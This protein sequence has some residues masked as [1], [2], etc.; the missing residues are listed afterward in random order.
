MSARELRG[1]AS[2]GKARGKAAR[3]EAPRGSHAVLELRPD[4]D[5]IAL[6]ELQAASRLS[7]LV[8]IRYG[9]MLV[10]P[11]SFFRGAAIVMAHDLAANPAAGLRAQLCGDAHLLNFGGFA[12]PERQLVFD[13]TDFDETLPGPFEWDVKRLA[14]SFEIAA[15]ECNFSDS[16][17]RRSVLS[18]VRSYRLAMHQFAAISHLDV[19]YAKLDVAATIAELRSHKVR[20]RLERAAAKA[21]GKDHLRAFGKLTHDVAGEP[22][23][24][25]DPP[26]VVPLAELVHGGGE[27]NDLESRLR[28]IFRNYRRTLQSDRRRLL[29]GFRYADLARNVVGVG[30]VGTRCWV[31]LLLGRDKREPLF[32][33]IKEAESSV[34]EPLVGQSGFA[35]HGQRVVEGQRLMQA[36]SDIFLGWVH[37]VREL[38]GR[39]RDFYVRQLWDWKATLEIETVRPRGLT[40][41]AEACGW[42]LARAHARSG[43]RIAI[44]EYL[45][46]SKAFDEAVAEFAAAYADLN[47]DDHKALVR[48]VRSGRLTAEG[49]L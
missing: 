15:R 23:I 39:P 22:R 35:S 33:Q 13:L 11:L 45:G 28:A 16:D 21:H 37:N 38:D 7:E 31:L 27:A 47:E 9:R 32:L 30:S 8:P 24:V 6:L 43:D 44:A 46:S 1:W 17:R 3:G 48:A 19:W 41:Y 20:N 34:L 12:S 18:A 25:S 36:A 49:R 26:L 5:P 40:L 42:T 2:E 4:R 10:S 14:A 29:E